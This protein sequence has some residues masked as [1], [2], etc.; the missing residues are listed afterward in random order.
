MLIQLMIRFFYK[1]RNIIKMSI[2]RSAFSHNAKIGNT[3]IRNNFYLRVSKEGKLSIGQGCFFNNGCSIVALKYISI[4][5]N[6]IFGENVKIY[7]HN[8]VFSHK[9]ILI[10]KQGFKCKGI[11]IGNNVWCG[12]NVVI[13]AGARIGNNCVIGAGCVVKGNIPD[14]TI[15]TINSIHKIQY[16]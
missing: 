7:D 12:T 13:L 10:K 6:C 5:D 8:H 1:I 4:G 16:K 11:E 14:D 2:Y 15:Y 3:F 9:N